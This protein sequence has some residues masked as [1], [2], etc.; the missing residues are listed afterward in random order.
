MSSDNVPYAKPQCQEERNISDIFH[1]LPNVKDVPRAG[2]RRGS[3]SESLKIWSGGGPCDSRPVPARWHWRLDR[4]FFFRQCVQRFFDPLGDQPPMLFVL[5][6][7]GG[8]QALLRIF[9]SPD[10]LPP[11]SMLDR[12][13]NATACFKSAHLSSPIVT[14]EPRRGAAPTLAL[15]TG[16]ALVSFEIRTTVNRHRR[17]P[18][19]PNRLRATIA[20]D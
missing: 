3:P 4:L 16:W 12:I 6:H 19:D 14:D 8:L 15:A 5:F 7:A 2:E 9:F 11:V 10:E 1:F 13:F 20:R 17:L 18:D